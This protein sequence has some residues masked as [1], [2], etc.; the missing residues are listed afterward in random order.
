MSSPLHDPKLEVRLAAARGLSRMGTD[1]E[2][3][4]PAIRRHLGG[5]D[6]RMRSVA[7]NL[8]ATVGTRSPEAERLVR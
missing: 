4:I 5:D 8:L 3:A 7:V 6:L 1:A 2:A